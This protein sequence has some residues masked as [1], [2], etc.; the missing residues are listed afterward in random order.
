[1]LFK[2]IHQIIQLTDFQYQGVITCI[3]KEGKDR[4]FIG[5]WRSISLLNSFCC[6]FVIANRIKPLLTFIISE[7]QKGSIKGRFIVENTRLLYDLMDYLN[8]SSSTP[9]INKHGESGSS[10]RQ[11]LSREKKNDM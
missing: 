8:E 11:P 9:I 3:S 1:M 4:R 7:S 5:N 10:C 6:T 2:I